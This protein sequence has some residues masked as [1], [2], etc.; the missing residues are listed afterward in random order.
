MN[1]IEIMVYFGYFVLS[2]SQAILN[3]KSFKVYDKFLLTIPSAVIDLLKL[4]YTQ[5]L[6]YHTSWPGYILLVIYI[7]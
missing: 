5:K 3:T 6:D 7:R 1:V 2:K 4:C